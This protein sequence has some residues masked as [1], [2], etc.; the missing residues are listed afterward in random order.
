MPRPVRPTPRP[1]P[2]STRSH[3]P[4][5]HHP[6]TQQLVPLVHVELS[7][8]GWASPPQATTAPPAHTVPETLPFWPEEMQVLLPLS[9]QPP[10]WHVVPP[11]QTSPG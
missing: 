6:P 7:Q 5:T 11:Q 3:H 4:P 8:Q 1:R 10:P 9:Q 2:G